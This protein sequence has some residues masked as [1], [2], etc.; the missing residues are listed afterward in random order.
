MTQRSFYWDNLRFYLIVLVVV[1]HGV[2][3]YSNASGLCASITL[4]INT[5]HM[6][7][8]I[9]ISGIFHCESNIKRRII[10]LIGYV[11]YMKTFNMEFNYLVLGADK[12]I[13][14]LYED[15]SPWFLIALA[16]FCGVTYI[17]R[18]IDKRYVFGVSIILALLVGYDAE[19][20]NSPVISRI[21]AWYPFYYLGSII[22]RNDVMI[23]LTKRLSRFIGASFIYMFAVLCICFKSRIWGLW[24]LMTPRL[25]KTVPYKIGGGGQLLHYILVALI[26]I[27]FMTIIPS[28]QIPGISKWGRNSLSVYMYHLSIREVFYKYGISDYLVQTSLGVIMLCCINVLITI[29]LS[30]DVVSIPA[31]YLKKLCY[32]QRT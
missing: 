23:F 25:Y 19:V 20:A 9:F 7:L 26:G 15:S 28:K 32:G 27:S 30:L 17:V 5:F 4:F 29:L 13:R 21:I 31:N 3:R 8:F 6:P 16:V 1:S 22:E 2:I 24:Y 10:I 11:F 14:L 18:D 12:N